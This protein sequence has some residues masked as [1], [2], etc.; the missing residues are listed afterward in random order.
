MYSHSYKQDFLRVDSDSA[1]QDTLV[2]RKKQDSSPKWLSADPTLTP[3]IAFY[4]V[5]HRNL[6]DAS[7]RMK[8]DGQIRIPREILRR[9]VEFHVD[10]T[11]AGRSSPPP[12]TPSPRPPMAW[13]WD[14]FSMK[15]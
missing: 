10:L 5:F 2:C 9:N 15:E 12:W 14:Q 6:D 8:R 13:N 3:N 7:W 1:H 4:G 11:L